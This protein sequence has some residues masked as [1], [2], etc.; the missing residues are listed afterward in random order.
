LLIG[1]LT[2][3]AKL[4]IA[5]REVAIAWRY[6]LSSTVDA[7]Q[8]SLTATTWLPNMLTGVMAI[9][10]V[11]RLVMLRHQRGDRQLFVAE[12][13]AAVLVLGIAVTILTWLAAPIV[14]TLLASNL[15]SQTTEL[16]AAMIARMAPVALFAILSGYM[17]ARLQSRER[18]G[19]SVTEAIPA[20]SISLFV[21]GSLGTQ[22]PQALIAGTLLGYLLQLPIL[23]F[24]TA[25]GDPPMG[26]FR[27]RHRSDE[28]ALMYGS[29][30]L[31]VSGQ[32][33]ITATIPI[34][35]GFAARI[36][37]GAV[38]SLGYANR[39][40]TLFSSLATLVVGRALLPV[41]SGAVADGD[42]M[43]GRRHT[44]Q[45][46]ALLGGLATAGSIIMWFAAPFLVRLLFQRGAFTTTD[47][48]EVASALQWGLVQLPFYFAGIALVQWYA[49][50]RRFRAFLLI[51]GSALLAKVLLNVVLTPHLGVHGIMISTAG[52]YFVTLAMLVVLLGRS[53]GSASRRKE[54]T[55]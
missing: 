30:L 21:I 50:T 36:G 43:L 7:Y 32:L 9:I 44:L 22:V 53:D 49:A 14:A 24:L 15:N 47:T 55:D 29:M 35:Q 19:Y 26:G 38:A 34:D 42:L 46:S 12:L 4:F 10:L 6:G 8:L 45:W 33:L 28:W 1:L 17:F 39:I 3:I 48:S 27:F 41:L 23:M 2:L 11:P 20:L 31:M 5:M 51:T 54:S 16:S 18:F 40:V 52:M 25:R 37:E 13:N